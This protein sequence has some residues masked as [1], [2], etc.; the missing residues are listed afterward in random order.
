MVADALSGSPEAKERYAEYASFVRGP[1]TLKKWDRPDLTVCRVPRDC[2]PFVL[3]KQGRTLRG[4]APDVVA[5]F[6]KHHG[7][8]ELCLFSH[9]ERAR[10]RV[11]L[12]VWAAVEY[13]RPG[14][15]LQRLDNDRVECLAL[16]D[17]DDCAFAFGRRGQTLAKLGVAAGCVVDL[18]NNAC[19][20]VGKPVDRARC[21][22][23][24]TA[25]LAQREASPHAP[26]VD[27][28]D[29]LSTNS[30]AV[31]TLTRDKG[32]R[33]R[34]I[35]SRTRTFIIVRRRHDELLVCSFSTSA[36]RNAMA[37]L[38]RYS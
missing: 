29:V 38:R 37:H 19:L 17:R 14:Y 18:V 4:L 1:V 6:A 7:H 34:Q 31:A 25:L 24:L 23:Y 16:L 11:E 15:Y 35:E 27:D 13:K 9:D 12:K 21:R 36:R 2:I 33:L 10:A 28:C 5:L 30:R 8:E 22:A 32:A 26:L 20:A 3:G